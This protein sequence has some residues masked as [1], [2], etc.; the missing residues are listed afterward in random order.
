[1]RL[2]GRSTYC[3]EFQWK[4]DW[5]SDIWIASNKYEVHLDKCREV[6]LMVTRL[7][8]AR[9]PRVASVAD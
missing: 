7:E 5:N 6:G 1:M 4:L 8:P 9:L 2:R 3:V